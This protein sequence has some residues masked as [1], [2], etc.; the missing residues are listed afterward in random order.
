MTTA[1]AAAVPQA[2]QERGTCGQSRGLD[3]VLPFAC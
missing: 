1:K 2:S 3:S